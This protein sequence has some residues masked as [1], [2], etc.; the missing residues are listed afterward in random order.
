MGEK[1]NFKRLKVSTIVLSTQKTSDWP[2]LE[3]LVERREISTY[4][5]ELLKYMKEDLNKAIL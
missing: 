5:I 2:V 3:Y 1:M 4:L